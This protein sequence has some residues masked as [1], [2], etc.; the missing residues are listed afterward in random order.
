MYFENEISDEDLNSN[1]MG[2]H[3][4]F[5][6]VMLNATEEEKRKMREMLTKQKKQNIKQFLNDLIEKKGTFIH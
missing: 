1:G 6:K 5:T 4:N 3:K 2:K